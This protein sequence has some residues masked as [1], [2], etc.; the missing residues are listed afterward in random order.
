MSGILGFSGQFLMFIL[1]FF[2]HHRRVT[3]GLSYQSW[4]NFLEKVRRRDSFFKIYFS[5]PTSS[6]LPLD[7]NIFSALLSQTSTSKYRQFK[8]NGNN[9][10][11]FE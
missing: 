1:C 9:C 5:H 7:A 3:L 6:S 10:F 8:Y 4:F 11:F 2:M